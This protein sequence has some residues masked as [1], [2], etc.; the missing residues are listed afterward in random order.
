MKEERTMVVYGLLMMVMMI[1][2]IT[3]VMRLRGIIKVL[4]VK[5]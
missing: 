3:D 2:Q 4:N 5:K 1:R